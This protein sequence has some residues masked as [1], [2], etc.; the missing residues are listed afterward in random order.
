MCNRT[1]LQ[2]PIARLKNGIGCK[3]EFG[4]LEYMDSI[5]LGGFCVVCFSD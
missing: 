4:G 3:Q 5:R 1:R 2:Q